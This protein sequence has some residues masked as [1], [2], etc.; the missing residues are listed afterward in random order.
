MSSTAQPQSGLATS[1]R[2]WSGFMKPSEELHVCASSPLRITKDPG[3]SLRLTD[4]RLVR[5]SPLPT[6]CRCALPHQSAK[7]AQSAAVQNSADAVLLGSLFWHR[8]FLDWLCCDYPSTLRDG[9]CK[10]QSSARARSSPTLSGSSSPCFS[11]CPGSGHGV[12]VS[13]L[14]GGLT[15]HILRD[16]ADASLVA[17]FLDNPVLASSRTI[18][19]RTCWAVASLRSGFLGLSRRVVATLLGPVFR[20]RL[21]R[22]P[23]FLS[24]CPVFLPVSSVRGA[25]R[26]PPGPV[27]PGSRAARIDGSS[28]LVDDGRATSGPTSTSCP[29]AEGRSRTPRRSQTPLA[30]E[31]RGDGHGSVRLLYSL[32][33]E[34]G[35]TDGSCKWPLCKVSLS[36]FSSLSPGVFLKCLLGWSRAETPPVV[37]VRGYLEG[38][39]R[40]TK[41]DCHV[42]RGCKQRPLKQGVFGKSHK[43][44]VYGRAQ[45]VRRYAVTLARDEELGAKV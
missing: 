6:S 41:G 32:P 38:I 34:S 9:S 19:A 12:Y 20:R 21:C 26:V 1:T 39:R 28:K 10:V 40:L 16:I 11:S 43:V 29:S 45:A 23:L 2:C 8:C 14:S 17:K 24:S 33:A 5:T 30:S 36:C 27:S 42:G 3:P 22:L 37:P 31:P 15:R 18:L 4:S 7:E 35:E 44:S 25:L 13:W